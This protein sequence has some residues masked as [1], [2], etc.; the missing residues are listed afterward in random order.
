MVLV[1]EDVLIRVDR[2]EDH[3]VI[4]KVNEDAFQRPDEAI[5]VRK[6]RQSDRLAVSLV[7]QL[8]DEVVGHAGLSPV[9][10]GFNRQAVNALGLAPVAVANLWQGAGIGSRLVEQAIQT[11]RDKGYQWLVVLGQP[12]FYR[13][14]G[15]ETASHFGLHCSF[16]V[17]DEAFMALPLQ[18]GALDAVRGTVYYAPEFYQ[19]ST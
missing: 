5:L 6:L 9:T 4:E 12:D 3:Q 15:F 14:F 16:V 10:L 13:R 17:P 8:D 11:V 19:T 18:P 1:T 7:A 2:R